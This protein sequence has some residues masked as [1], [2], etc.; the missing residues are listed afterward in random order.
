MKK[1][2]LAGFI[3]IGL[4]AAVLAGFSMAKS[5]SAKDSWTTQVITACDKRKKVIV[6]G[7]REGEPLPR[8]KA[9]QVA[10]VLMGLMK[11]CDYE[12]VALIPKNKMK[13]TV[14]LDGGSS[15]EVDETDLKLPI[16]LTHGQPHTK[17]EIRIWQAELKRMVKTGYRLFHSDELGTNGIACDMCHPDA[18]NTHPETYPKFQTQLEEV[19]LL[20]DMINW[21]IENP[22]EGETLPDDSSKMKA[23]EA[24]IL[25]ARK[26]VALDAGKH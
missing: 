3:T 15:F 11:Y 4:S 23:L 16:V 7:Y 24:Y 26:G 14:S 18:S 13:I 25:S 12:V 5:Q 22:M 2:I 6:E 20:R 8:K 10:R 21:C 9:E 17:R 19:A 1:R